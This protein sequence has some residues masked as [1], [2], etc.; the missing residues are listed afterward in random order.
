MKKSIYSVFAVLIIAF[1]QTAHADIIL[2]AELPAMGTPVELL[3]QKW[4]KVYQDKKKL[5]DIQQQDRIQMSQTGIQHLNTWAVYW[6]QRIPHKQDHNAS[7]YVVIPR[8][9]VVAP[10]AVIP[11]ASPDYKFV[12]QWLSIDF[13]QYLQNGVVHY[14]GSSFGS[15]WNVVLAG[16]SSYR[17]SDSGRYKTIFAS[18]PLLE[19]G[20]QIRVYVK[21]AQWTYDRYRYMVQKSFQTTPTNVDILKNTD[22]QM[23]TLF[24]CVPIGTVF[25][26]RVVQATLMRPAKKLLYAPKK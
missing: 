2:P 21:N 12:T 17:K 1:V 20:D 15:T 8:L 13:N 19:F 24:T 16:H 23:I 4:V 3:R 22:T 11:N 7:Q 5:L 10:I 18:L 25:D 6:I 14:P 9:W 26:R